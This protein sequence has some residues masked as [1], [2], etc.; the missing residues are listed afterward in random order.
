MAAKQ[1]QKTSLK[2]RKTDFIMLKYDIVMKHI[3][4]TNSDRSILHAF[5]NIGGRPVDTAGVNYLIPIIRV[6][7]TVRLGSLSTYQNTQCRI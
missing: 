3:H 1:K 4:A 7:F 5:K 6:L 2:I